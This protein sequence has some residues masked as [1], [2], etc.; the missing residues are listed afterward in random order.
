MTLKRIN[1]LWNIARGGSVAGGILQLAGIH[2]G[3]AG[4]LVTAPAVF[5]LMKATTPTSLSGIAE[6]GFAPAWSKWVS[7]QKQ[8]ILQDLLAKSTF[9]ARQSIGAIARKA[10]R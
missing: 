8:K 9:G 3:A 4:G 6:H 1:K 7:P 2:G 10:T 5:G